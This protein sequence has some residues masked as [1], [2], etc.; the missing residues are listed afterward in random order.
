[1][2]VPYRPA[3]RS[4]T[5]FRGLV[6]EP[7]ASELVPALESYRG[8]LSQNVDVILLNNL[9]L[10]LPALHG[11]SGRF[12]GPGTRQRWSP[13]RVRWD[14]MVGSVADEVHAVRSRSTRENIRRTQRRIER[15][16]GDRA[17]MRILT[18]PE[19]AERVFQDIDA[20]AVKTYQTA[21]QPIFAPSDLDPQARDAWPR[22]GLVPRVHAVHRGRAGRFLGPVSPTG[23][24]SAG[25]A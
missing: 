23:A 16:F 15:D 19:D 18:R 2:G 3:L 20:V 10:V 17:E 12:P 4:L 1:M 25:A 9:D 13:E 24:C 21:S 14:T 7:T 22:E 8:E 5:F 6:G 11:G